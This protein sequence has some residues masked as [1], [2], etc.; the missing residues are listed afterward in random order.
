MKDDFAAQLF[1]AV[2]VVGISPSGCGTRKVSAPDNLVAPF[3]YDSQAPLD[4]QEVGAERRNDVMVRDIT[5]AAPH[6]ERVAAYL[7]TP[8]GKGPYPAVLYVHWLDIGPTAKANRNQFLDEA[9]LLAE[10]GVTSLLVDDIYSV[11]GSRRSWRSGTATDDR[12]EVIQQVVELRTALDLLITE[13][14]ADPRRI[15]LVGHDFGAMFGIV[16]TGI[17]PRISTCVVMTAVPDFSDWFLMSSALM[18]DEREAYRAD[19]QA[20]APV[21]YAAYAAPASLFF[22]FARR[23]MYVS[24]KRANALFEA[25]SEPKRIEWYESGHGLHRN[26]DATHDRLEWLRTELGLRDAKE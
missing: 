21:Q 2:I 12:E 13:A 14:H 11:P 22:Q 8:D 26:E 19:L 1:A 4:L 10:E 18:L 15:A 9:V 6:G 24:E 3:D 5:F 20:V 17:D 7:A 23:D 16:L 25:A